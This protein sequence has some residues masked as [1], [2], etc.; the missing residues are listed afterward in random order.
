[1]ALS[2]ANACQ[3]LNIVLEG[4]FFEKCDLSGIGLNSLVIPENIKNCCD[5]KKIIKRIFMLT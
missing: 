2:R 4:E 5:N 3:C 1:M